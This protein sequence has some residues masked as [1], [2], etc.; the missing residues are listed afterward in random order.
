MNKLLI[1]DD[2]ASI[3]SSLKFALEDEYKVYTA[4]NLHEVQ[5]IINS[6]EIAIVLLDLKFG[7]MSGIDVLSYIKKVHKDTVVIMMTAYGCIESSIEAIKNGA[8]DYIMKPLDMTKLKILLKNAGEHGSL[9]EKINYLTKEVCQ[10]YGK[11]GLIGKSKSIKE[12]FNLIEKMKDIDIN[13]LIQGASGTGKELVARAIHYQGKRRDARFEA[14][15]C[16]A[17]PAS[18][19]ESELFGH[20]KG[21]FTHA[22]QKKKGRFE[23]ADGGTIFLDEIGELDLNLQVKLLRFIQEKEIYPLGS[24]HSKK[25]DVRII[26]ATNKD[27]KSEVEKG[28]FREDLFFRLNVVTIKTPPLNERTE[29]IPLLIE[30]FIKKWSN[31]IGKNVKGITREALV[32]LENHH[33]KGNIRELENIIERA[34]ALTEQD[35]IQ[36]EDLPQELRK[37]ENILQLFSHAGIISIKT[38]QSLDTVEKQVILETLKVMDGNRKKT[39]EVLGISERSLRYKLADYNKAFR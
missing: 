32:L 2:E 27:L 36:V 28:N 24:Q 11:N 12:V 1:I 16:S 21:A 35:Y 19:I 13:V 22:L 39:A 20:E 7:D 5:S 25:V 30:H 23:L 26:A 8:Y 18:L 38:G 14:L 17:I 4:Q 6:M 15:N 33:Y 29:D 10:K 37:E 34:L 31:D 9:Q 3:C